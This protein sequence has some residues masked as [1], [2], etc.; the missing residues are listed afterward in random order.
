VRMGKGSH[1]DNGRVIMLIRIVMG[2]KDGKVRLYGYTMIGRTR[3]KQGKFNKRRNNRNR[4]KQ[5]ECNSRGHHK[6]KG[7]EKRNPCV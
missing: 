2:E 7:R 4:C 5:Q 3:P 6:Y 1:R